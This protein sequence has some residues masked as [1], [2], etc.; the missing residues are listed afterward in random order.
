[1]TPTPLAEVAPGER[2]TL[3]ERPT[4][5][6]TSAAGR[7]FATRDESACLRAC[8]ALAVERC[9]DFARA[10]DLLTERERHRATLL[11]ALADC[12][13]DVA[14]GPGEITERIEN[15]NRIAFQVAR[16]LRGEPS[17][18]RFFDLFAVE[19]K[20]RGFTRPALDELFAAAR[21]EARAPRPADVAELDLRGQRLGQALATALLGAEPAPAVVD[22]AAGL[23]RLT[24]LQ[25]LSLD[26]ARKTSWIPVA[27][28]ADPLQ[29][30]T[31]DEIAAAVSRE[32]GALHNLL[33]KGARA[34]GEVPLTF[35]R[36]VA[37]VLPVAI[38]LLG[39]IEERPRAIARSVRRVGLWK[40]RL[41]HWR[42]RYTPLA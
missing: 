27:E 39:L 28:L 5:S 29:Y 25:R 24:R 12:L 36:P 38:A 23:L 40:L 2:P 10:L 4:W 9:G 20:R 13:F 41:T 33:L 26:L 30:R 18:S 7:L 8:D 32:C 42:A 14:T 16:S 37:F 21:L 3:F 17:E 34:A 11:V 1:V 31:E 22:L 15:L 6:E 35:R 19:A